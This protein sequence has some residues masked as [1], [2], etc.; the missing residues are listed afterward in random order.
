MDLCRLSAG[1]GLKGILAIE[2][3]DALTGVLLDTQVVDN[4]TVLAGRNLLRDFLA[5][6]V[7]TGLTHFAVGTG[8]TAAAAGNTTLQTEKF[9]DAITQYI[10]DAAKLTI[11]FYL[12]SGSANGH[13]LT[14][15][16]IFTGTP[17]GTMYC[18]A[19]YTGIVK[20]AAVT[21]TYSWDLTFTPA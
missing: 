11:R 12:P 8:T 17:A 10:E 3:R 5:R 4:L 13:T 16:G 21:V 1:I 6:D 14:E 2:V 15:A 19:V 7:V 18:R 9:R 20:T